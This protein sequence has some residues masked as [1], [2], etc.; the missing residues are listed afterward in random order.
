MSELEELQKDAARWRALRQLTATSLTP[1]IA[2]TC[3]GRL[4]H[5]PDPTTPIADGLGVDAEDPARRI[6]LTPRLTARRQRL[7][8][9]A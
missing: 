1:A 5:A 4:L 9:D 6:H 3:N 8:C 7:T 2:T